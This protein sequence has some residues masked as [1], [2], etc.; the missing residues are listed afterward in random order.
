M[1]DGSFFPQ[2][3]THM[4]ACLEKAPICPDTKHLLYPGVTVIRP[5]KG[6]DVKLRAC[7]A[8]VFAQDYPNFELILSV[9]D[10]ADPAVAVAQQLIAEY[11]HVDVKLCIGMYSVATGQ[12]V[13][14]IAY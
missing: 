12:L 4:A 9:S 5:M 3:T 13:S 2:P 11:P 6:L 14:L 8:S 1:P 10:A 7:L